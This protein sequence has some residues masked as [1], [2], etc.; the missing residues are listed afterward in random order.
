MKKRNKLTEGSTK[1]NVKKAP[2]TGKQASPPPPIDLDFAALYQEIPVKL[3]DIRPNGAEA[4]AIAKNDISKIG[5]VGT[6]RIELIASI[7]SKVIG[8]NTFSEP[9]GCIDY[10][11]GY[12][13][14][15]H[16]CKKCKEL[17]S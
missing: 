6:H 17:E 8:G 13:R 10:S 9:I 7:A 11:Q 12:D 3:S 15:E 1:S 4:N 16:Q 5:I 2:T 14:C